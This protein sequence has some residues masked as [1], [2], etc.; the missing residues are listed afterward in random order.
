VHLVGSAA[1]ELEI[2]GERQGVGPGLA[3]RLADVARLERRKFLGPIRDELSEPGQVRPRSNAGMRP[4]SPSSARR[5]ASTASFTSSAPPRAISA[6]VSP[7]LGLTTGRQPPTAS[8]QRPS[9]N[10]CPSLI[11]MA[12]SSITDNPLS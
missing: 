5:A 8:R 11:P 4:Q 2:A 6:K 10:T 9:I 7:S 1:V 12:S 3:Q